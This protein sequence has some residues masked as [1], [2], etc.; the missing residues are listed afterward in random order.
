MTDQ[1][2]VAAAP[3]VAPEL[4]PL[5]QAL[6]KALAQKGLTAL[7]TFLTGYGVITN[8]QQAQVISLG[9]SVAL[10]AA[11]FAWTYAHEH[12]AQAKLVAAINA[13]APV[14]K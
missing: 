5:W 8:D 2:P 1:P 14:A 6:V 11:S 7:A 10:W 12:H 9:L 13:P 4:P 3:V